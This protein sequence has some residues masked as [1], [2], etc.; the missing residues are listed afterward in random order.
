M[1]RDDE[2]IFNEYVLLLDDSLIDIF[3]RY[4]LY[5]VW[6]KLDDRVIVWVWGFIHYAFKNR[7]MLW[8]SANLVDC[9]SYTILSDARSK[10][11]VVDIIRW[12]YDFL[13]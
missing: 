8:W 3:V 6:D 12:Y 5:A 1:N 2:V 13:G 11:F 4:F 9:S 7:G 10:N